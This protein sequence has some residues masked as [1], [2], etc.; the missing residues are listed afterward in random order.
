MRF[1]P[2]RRQFVWGGL[3]LTLLYG[4]WIAGPYLRSIVV[5]DAAV[6]TWL[7]LAMSPIDGL[8]VETPLRVGDRIDRDGRIVSIANPRVDTTAL[9]TARASLDRAEARVAALT[10]LLNDLETLTRVRARQAADYAENFRQNLDTKIDGM[11]EFLGASQRRLALERAEAERLSKLAPIGFETRSALDAA[12][13]RVASAEQATIDAQTGLNGATLQRKAA[14][15]GLL[16]LD[17]G[18]DGLA[19]Q[20]G[21][22]DARLSR[23]RARADLAAAQRDA[24]A[25]RQVLD[26]T[27]RLL[28]RQRAAAILGSP[29]GMVL[30]LSAT[31]DAAVRAGAPI[32]AWVD[33]RVMLVD[34][35]V[36]DVALSLVRPGGPARVVLEGERRARTGTVLLMRGSAAT[37][38]SADLAA[39]AKGRHAGVGQVIVGLEPTP[40]DLESCPIGRAAFVHFPDVNVLRVIRARLRW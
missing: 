19:V 37:L 24:D 30:S 27:Q 1:E 7:H 35:P 11:A 23:D 34:A 17:D 10:P 18:S 5:R 14:E 32:A 20:R 2:T 38:G 6:T 26:E 39:V 21:F 4:I 29:G 40:E 16:F 3:L 9:A 36:S 12:L 13:A 8:V 25:A 28:D 22:E 31:R 15:G 33:C